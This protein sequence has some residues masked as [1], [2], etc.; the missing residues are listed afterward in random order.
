MPL[1][2]FQESVHPADLF[3]ES[4]SRHWW[5]YQTRPRAEKTFSR[6]LARANVAHFCPVYSHKWRKNGRRFESFL[7]L[8]PNYVFASGSDEVRTVAFAS[9]LIVREVP[10][11]NQTQLDRELTTV[12]RLLGGGDSLR[13]EDSLARGTPVLIV[14]GIYAGVYGQFID[15]ADDLRVH[16]EIE[17]LGRGVSVSVERWMVKPLEAPGSP[18]GRFSVAS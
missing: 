16:V 8:F 6:R 18:N 10:V 5:V 4:A 12:H 7:P 2:P 14:K 13:P 1:L 9:D 11:H 15:A 17:M 3:E